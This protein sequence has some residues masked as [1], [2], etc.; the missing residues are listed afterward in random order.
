MAGTSSGPST[1]IR[2]ST[3]A[4]LPG[5][6]TPGRH[7]Q[8]SILQPDLDGV[9]AGSRDAGWGV[10]QQVAAAEAFDH[11]EKHRS[12]VG[13]G[14]RVQELSPRVVD[15]DAKEERAKAKRIRQEAF[16]ETSG[17]DLVQL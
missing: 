3:S 6:A 2:R 13:T 12:Q 5:V 16:A 9:P 10:A 15:D 1:S 8:R 7:F 11:I 14:R 4:F 17:R